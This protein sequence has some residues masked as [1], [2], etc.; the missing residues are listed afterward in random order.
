MIKFLFYAAGVTVTVYM[1]IIYNRASLIFLAG[2][3]LLPLLLLLLLTVQ[4]AFLHLSFSQK[5]FRFEDGQKALSFGL[6]VKNGPFPLRKLTVRIRADNLTTGE[7]KE[8]RISRAV[9]SGTCMLSLWEE[10]SCGVWEISCEKIRLFDFLLFFR[11]RKWENPKC[12][13]LCFPKI[14]NIKNLFFSDTSKGEESSDPWAVG[15]DTSVIR[16]IREYRPG[17]RLRNIHWKLSAKKETLQVKEY[18]CT[19]GGEL[20]FGLDCVG[21][22]T[23]CLELVYSLLKGCLSCHCPV[24]FVWMQPEG[25][26][27]QLAVTMEE[28][29]ALALELLMRQGAAPFPEDQRPEMKIPQ[30]W[31]L[32]GRKLTLDGKAV[33]IFS[34]ERLEEQLSELELP[35]YRE[36]GL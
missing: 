33:R 8:H 17:D 5:Q 21:L 35:F 31:L 32:E 28:Q 4:R 24:R 1:G 10:F 2:V 9:R 18:G 23:L 26:A 30:L 7:S 13:L 6:L 27:R 11:I 12:E 20:L 29:A 19:L 34:K 15:Q 22:D 36:S 25:E 14:Y 3:E 16:E